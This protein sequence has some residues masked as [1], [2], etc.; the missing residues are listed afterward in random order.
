MSS[1]NIW[2]CHQDRLSLPF[3]SLGIVPE[4][5]EHG[6]IC[7]LIKKKECKNYIVYGSKF[8]LCFSS[9]HFLSFSLMTLM[10]LIYTIIFSVILNLF[11][12][13]F[14][15]VT[16][17]KTLAYSLQPWNDSYLWEEWKERQKE[18]REDISS[19]FLNLRFVSLEVLPLVKLMT[20]AT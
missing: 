9:S 8:K 18:T 16:S 2:R 20:L 6:P 13:S 15:E 12:Y 17:C 7:V 5:L 10:F 19:K 1:N 11:C 3:I 4:Y 14:S